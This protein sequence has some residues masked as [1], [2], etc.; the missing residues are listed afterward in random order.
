MQGT[1]KIINMQENKNKNLYVDSDHYNP[2][3][4][5]EI[6]GEIVKI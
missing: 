5:D 3:F 4:S 1:K 6:A 2:A